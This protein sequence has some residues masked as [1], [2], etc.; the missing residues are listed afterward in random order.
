MG[1][2]AIVIQGQ[3]KVQ[4]GYWILRIKGGSGSLEPAEEFIGMGIYEFAERVKRS[5][6]RSILLLLGLQVKSACLPP[7][8]VLMIKMGVLIGT[9]PAV[10][11]GLLWGAKGLKA[12]VIEDDC[13]NSSVTVV[14]QGNFKD[15]RRKLIEA[16]RGHRMTKPG[17]LLNTYGMSF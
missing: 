8:Y 5:T 16:L 4:N 17:G 9:Q 10:D 14:K 3:P 6:A 7:G 1:I 15:G 2:K 11:W 12:I 13:N